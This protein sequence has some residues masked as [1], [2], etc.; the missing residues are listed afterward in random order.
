[1]VLIFETLFSKQV[2]KFNY[3][4]K[5]TSCQGKLEIKSRLQVY[6]YLAF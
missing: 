3:G 5:V 2:N 4:A 1:M 6:K